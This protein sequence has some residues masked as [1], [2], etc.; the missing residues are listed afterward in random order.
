MLTLEQ[1]ATNNETF[2]HIERVRNLLNACV[3]EL[4]KRGE[5]H[6]QTKL[7]SPEVEVFAEYTPKLAG[8]TYGSDEYKGFLEVTAAEH[9]GRGRPPKAWRPADRYVDGPGVLPDSTKLF[10]QHRHADGQISPC[11]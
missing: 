3:V 1:R 4:L 11:E 8:C 2:R 10:R 7:D 6:D 5:L 9:S